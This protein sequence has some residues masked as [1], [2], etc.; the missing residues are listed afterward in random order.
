MNTQH[1]FKNWL[2]A[3]RHTRWVSDTLGWVKRLVFSESNE[4]IPDAPDIYVFQMGKVAST[5]IV[6]SLKTYGIRTTQLHYLNKQA[7]R[8]LI[9]SFDDPNMSPYFARNHAEQLARNLVLY[10]RFIQHKTLKPKLEDGSSCLKIITLV[11][12]PFAWYLSNLSQNYHDYE[13]D[14][15]SYINGVSADPSRYGK[16]GTTEAVKAFLLAFSKF[17]A[18]HLDQL[19]EAR[20][21]ELCAS[22]PNATASEQIL[23]KHIY[24]LMRAQRWLEEHFDPV[25]ETRMSD[26]PFEWA[27]GYATYAMPYCDILLLRFESLGQIGEKAIGGFLDIPDFRLMRHNVSSSKGIGRQIMAAAREVQ[28]HS[29]FLNLLYD[30]PYSRKYYSTEMIDG[31]KAKYRGNPT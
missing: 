21:V 1:L 19:N 5:S 18:E 9:D 4:N 31:F 2:I 7:F 20:V 22:R 28:V 30:T 27:S 15:E 29:G 16:L 6:N 14:I 12:E 3:F 11:R 8:D 24:V 10:N 25:V 23:I 17:I 26:Q 13:K